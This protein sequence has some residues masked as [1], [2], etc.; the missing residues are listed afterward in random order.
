[1][2]CSVMDRQPSTKLQMLHLRKPKFSYS[3]AWQSEISSTTIHKDK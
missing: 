3:L 1:M 2:L